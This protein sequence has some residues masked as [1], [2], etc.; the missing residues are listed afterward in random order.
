MPGLRFRRPPALRRIAF[1]RLSSGFP[2]LAIVA[3]DELLGFLQVGGLHVRS[4]PLHALSFADAQSDAAEQND[5]REIRR[6]VEV[7]I[8]W[9]AVLH[10]AEPLGL[11]TEIAVCVAF[12]AR[13][14]DGDILA[15]IVFVARNEFF[16]ALHRD[17][18]TRAII[19]RREYLALFADDQRAG[20]G[21]RAHRTDNFLGQVG[22]GPNRLERLSGISVVPP[23]F[24]WR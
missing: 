7:R 19:I 10:H 2:A 9:R 23:E 5:F 12:V 24:Q 13:D 4:I 21:Q 20:Y 3:P 17:E 8:G 11:L 16:L 1:R 22:I 14:G 18:K 15:G 6:D